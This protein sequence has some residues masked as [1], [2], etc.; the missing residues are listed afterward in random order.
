M[1]GIP[2][3]IQQAPVAYIKI[4]DDLEIVELNAAAASLGIKQQDL[5]THYLADRDAVVLSSKLEEQNGFT[6]NVVVN[7]PV[8]E[9]PVLVQ[10]IP[11]GGDWHIWM[12]DLSEQ[13]ALASRVRQL[14]SPLNKVLKQVQ[15]HAVT[16][17]GY[18]ELLTV[19][20]EDEKNFSA[21]K[22][23]ALRQYQ[24]EITNNLRQL[25]QLAAKE[26]SSEVSIGS[27]RQTV[28]VVDQHKELT[29]LISELL[30]TQGYK[31]VSFS[32][33]EKAIRY[34]EING[35][36]IS[37]AVIDNE[38]CDSEGVNLTKRVLTL[39]P[40]LS[41]IKLVSEVIDEEDGSV[42]KPVNFDELL[43]AI[44]SRGR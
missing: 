28:L 25:Q 29:A 36:K 13:T 42:C 14:K 24:T 31:V 23:S 3:E 27:L 17:L 44:E 40:S 16:G 15:H 6:L 43:A 11:E 4:K 2:N 8:S 35:E 12:I 22:L 21:E 32:D 18:S 19:I 41:I 38:L 26:N 34:C 5:L 39:K 33:P 37:T 7:S 9:K 10:T 20:L 1:P 30:I